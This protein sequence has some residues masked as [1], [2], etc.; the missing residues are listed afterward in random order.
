MGVVMVCFCLE[1]SVT[2]HYSEPNVV[3]LTPFEEK[4]E[5]AHI[6]TKCYPADTNYF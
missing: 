3:Y 4:N 1:C 6:L 2:H 5:K